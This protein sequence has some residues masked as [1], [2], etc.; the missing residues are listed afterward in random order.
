MTPRL[1][2]PALRGLVVSAEVLPGAVVEP[3]QSAESSRGAAAMVVAVLLLA[4]PGAVVEPRQS[5][6]S[7]LVGPSLAAVPAVLEVPAM[8]EASTASGP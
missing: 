4:E 3:R 5:A 8:F 6:E 7:V 1:G 2:R